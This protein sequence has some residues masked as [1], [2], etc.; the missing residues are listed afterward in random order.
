MTFESLNYEL[1]IQD[2]AY[3]FMEDYY[4]LIRLSHC[5]EVFLKYYIML[6]TTGKTRIV[7]V[8]VKFS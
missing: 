3:Q 2:M 1:F 5:C 8:I 4:H 7:Q 6:R